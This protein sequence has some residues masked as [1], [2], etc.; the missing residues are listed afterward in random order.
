ML[1]DT[2]GWDNL[3]AKVVNPLKGV[4]IG[5]YYGCLLLRPSNVMQFDNP[6]NPTILEDFIKAIG[7]T[8]VTYA[9]R[10]ECC[11]AYVSLKDKE[12]VKKT[13]NRIVNNAKANGAEML[14]T[15]C[16]ACW[17]NLK[18]NSDGSVKVAVY[19]LS[20]ARFC[21]NEGEMMTIMLKVADNMVAGDYE[22]SIKNQIFTSSDIKAVT[23]NGSI[24]MVKVNSETGIG[25]IGENGAVAKTYDMQGRPS[26]AKQHGVYVVN[27]KKVVK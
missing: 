18:K 13:A 24:A 9:M 14:I 25:S 22:M 12:V 16:P 23:A 2:V 21:G 11:G 20:N 4:K 27:N 1:R 6:E 15:A 5:A 10:N 19:S 3:K 17:Y 26:K 7:A 8:P